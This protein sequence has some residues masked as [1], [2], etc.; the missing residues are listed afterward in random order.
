MSNLVLSEKHWFVIGNVWHLMVSINDHIYTKSFIIYD[1]RPGC[2][3]VV[4]T[5]KKLKEADLI[6]FARKELNVRLK[7]V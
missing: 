7:L 2:E 5:N 1:T 6:E 4:E 3:S